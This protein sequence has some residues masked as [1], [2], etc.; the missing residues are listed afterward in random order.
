MVLHRLHHDAVLLRGVGHL[1]APRAADGR[2]WHIAVAA[3]LIGG[4][5]LQVQNL[6]VTNDLQ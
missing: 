3:N 6:P 5:D 2:V 1:H 4:V